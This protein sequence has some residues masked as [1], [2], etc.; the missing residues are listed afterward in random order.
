MNKNYTKMIRTF[1]IYFVILKLYKISQN[2]Y[3][4]STE[5]IQKYKRDCVTYNNIYCINDVN[6][7]NKKMNPLIYIT[8]E[9]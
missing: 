9:N 8:I 2:S 7:Y 4:H 6:I 3:I 5:I 1:I